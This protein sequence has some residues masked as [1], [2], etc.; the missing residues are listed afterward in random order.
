MKLSIADVKKIISENEAEIRKF[1]VKEIYLF[2]SVV[3]GEAKE[4]SD[5]DLFVVLDKDARVGLIKFIK[6]QMYLT[7]ILGKKVDLAT[8]ASL[9]PLLKDQ[10]LK[11]AIRAA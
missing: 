6:L 7:A 3:R 10:I 11:E 8:K 5:V 1:G 2:G 4:T 9:H